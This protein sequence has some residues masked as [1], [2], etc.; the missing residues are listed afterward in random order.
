MHNPKSLDTLV[1]LF[2]IFGIGALYALCGVGVKL[3]FG[4]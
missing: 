2:V 3:L 1:G 4:A